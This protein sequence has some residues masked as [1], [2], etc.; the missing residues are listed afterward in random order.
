MLIRLRYYIYLT[1]DDHDD[2]QALCHGCF[3][4]IAHFAPE[5]FI[6]I[7]DGLVDNLKVKLDKLKKTGG[8]AKVDTKKRDDLM[9]NIKRLF[10]EIKRVNEV[11]ENPK[12]IDLNNEVQAQ[13]E[14]S[15]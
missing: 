13:L 9:I 3:L 10:D 15:K 11:E 4:K 12:F 1:L 6:A 14:K 8:E 2:I 7:L 5:T